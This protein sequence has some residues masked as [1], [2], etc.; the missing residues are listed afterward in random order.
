MNRGGRATYH[1]P[2]QVVMYPLIRLDEDCPK[3]IKAK[4]LH[5]YMRVLEEALV[6]T[7]QTYGIQAEGHDTQVAMD[8]EVI[9]ATGV[10]F[11]GQKLASIGIAVRK[12]VASHG[13]ALNLYQD[14]E[15]F[16]GIHPCG[17]STSTMTSVEAILGKKLDRGDFEDRLFLEFSQKIFL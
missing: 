7:L 14:N 8:G 6:A 2:S 10:W 12:W 16:Q 4:D 11:Q 17:F 9:E 13:L 3:P 15:A 5:G 1:G